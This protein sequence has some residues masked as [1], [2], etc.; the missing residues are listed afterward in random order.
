MSKFPQAQAE[1][2][3]PETNDCRHCPKEREHEAYS[4][5][6][7][8]RNS[9]KNWRR[10]WSLKIHFIRVYTLRNRSRT[11]R[12]ITHLRYGTRRLLLSRRHRP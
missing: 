9:R 10:C 3:Q 7:F 4:P 2:T 11:Y 1:M 8:S 12:A 5:K 6:F